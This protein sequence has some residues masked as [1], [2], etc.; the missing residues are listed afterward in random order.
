MP[1]LP[2]G[3]DVLA[4]QTLTSDVIAEGRL[5]APTCI[6]AKTGFGHYF[7]SA[8]GVRESRKVGVFKA[9]LKR[10]TAKA[11]DDLDRRLAEN[12]VAP[13]ITS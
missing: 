5:V 9:W 7:V 4:W 8:K 10:K 2:D 1:S 6:R 3:R 12:G 13:A 11:S